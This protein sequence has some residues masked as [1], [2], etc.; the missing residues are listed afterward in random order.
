MNFGVVIIFIMELYARF[1]L[2]DFAKTQ[3]LHKERTPYMFNN[4]KILGNTSLANHQKYDVCI[5]FL[6]SV[7]FYDLG[8]PW[9]V[10]MLQFKFKLEYIAPKIE[11]LT[12]SSVYYE[13]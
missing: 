7:F 10:N 12:L 5:Y 2:H 1:V 6:M 3:K 9:Q 13:H 8:I 11:S 4:H